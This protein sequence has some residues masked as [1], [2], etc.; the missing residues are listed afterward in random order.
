MNNLRK[1]R[2]GTYRWQPYYEW[3]IDCPD[4]DTTF[5]SDHNGN[6]YCNGEVYMNCPY[7]RP[8]SKEREREYN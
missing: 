8:E 1:E 6:I 4:C 3:F 2:D 7:Y 5:L